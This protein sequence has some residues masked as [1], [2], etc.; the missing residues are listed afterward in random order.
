MSVVQNLIKG[1]KRISPSARIRFKTVGFNIGVKTIFLNLKN[2]EFLG[3][4]KGWNIYLNIV[5]FQKLSKGFNIL[6]LMRNNRSKLIIWL[7]VLIYN[8]FQLIHQIIFFFQS[9]S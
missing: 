9:I 6:S 7:L 3:S 4:K 2:L 8:F 1:V 5:V